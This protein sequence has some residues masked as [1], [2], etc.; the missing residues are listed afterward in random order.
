MYTGYIIKGIG[1]FYYVKTT[2]GVIECKAKGI[3][4][5]R[6][7]TPVAGDFVEYQEDGGTWIITEILE[8][9]NIFVRPPIANVD[10]FFVIAST[11]EPVPSTLI[12]DMLTAI[13][14]DKGAKPYILIT[15]TD[16]LK[17][18]WLVQAYQKST[19][20][21]ICVNAE[22]KEG[23]AEVKALLKD[24]ISVFCGNSGVGKSTLLSAIL[25]NDVQL[26]TGEISKKLG[27]G[28]HTTREVEL[29]EAE[30]GLV[31][32][33][34]GFSSL[35]MVKAAYLPKENLQYAFPD[36]AAYFGKCKFT[37][38]S[39]TSEKG[40]AVLLALQ[41]G[42]ISTTRYESYKTLYEQAKEINDW[43]R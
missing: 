24:K 10:N 5:K 16:I 20:P 27:R 3:F 6:R 32:D 29:F 43:E 2:D 18:D 7:I 25:P 34:P 42:E 35:E 30:G 36:I 33:T 15:K 11:T 13:A 14:V 40:C 41:N 22:N 12:I 21:V 31:A 37:G 9:K 8:R 19:I 17:S 38:C 28:K 39:H 1:G 23:I 26:T 4:R